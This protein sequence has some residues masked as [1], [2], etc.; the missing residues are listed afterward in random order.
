MLAA[1]VA[2]YLDQ[3]DL[4]KY[5]ADGT[6]G[7]IYLQAYPPSPDNFIF[8]RNTGG[9]PS[10]PKLPVDIPTVQILVRDINQTNAEV[11]AQNIYNALHGLG[12]VSI[13]DTWVIT[14]RGIQSAPVYI[15]VDSNN[16][17]EFS[18]NFEITIL[19]QTDNRE[20]W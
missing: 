11:K 17:H 2:T 5:D 4:G 15:G 14:C 10:S 20:V 13:G 9:N 7:N 3:I 8:I 19:N 6:T 16:R 1:D 12:S 18:L